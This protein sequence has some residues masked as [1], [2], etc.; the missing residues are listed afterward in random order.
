M[1]KVRELA[2]FREIEPIRTAIKVR[3]QRGGERGA[4]VGEECKELR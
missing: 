4:R 2:Q 3:R 1:V